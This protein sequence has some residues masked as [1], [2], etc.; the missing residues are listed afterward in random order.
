[1]TLPSAYDDLLL[2]KG[3]SLSERFGIADIA[4]RREDALVG[5]DLLLHAGCVILG[6]D[7]YFKDG[8]HLSLAYANWFT[9]RKEGEDLADFVLRSHAH[10]VAYIAN[11]PENAHHEALFSLVTPST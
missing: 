5:A 3:F 2:N 4:L 8:E 6:G 1:M 9:D 7:V 11:F 10:T